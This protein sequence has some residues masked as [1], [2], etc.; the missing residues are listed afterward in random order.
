MR[1]T[2][3]DSSQTTFASRLRLDIGDELEI[4]DLPAAAVEELS[5]LNA[6]IVRPVRILPADVAAASSITFPN[7]DTLIRCN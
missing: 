1:V 5:A 4:A 7:G 2:L 6:T 3:R